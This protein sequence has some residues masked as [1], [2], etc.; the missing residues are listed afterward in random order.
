MLVHRKIEV[1]EHEEKH[2]ITSDFTC[3]AEVSW[4]HAVQE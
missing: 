2:N 4:R 1:M 3:V